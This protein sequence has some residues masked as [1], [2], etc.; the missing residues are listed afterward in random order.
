MLTKLLPIAMARLH[1]TLK[2]RL[3]GS[4]VPKRKRTEPIDYTGFRSFPSHC[5]LIWQKIE[6]KMDVACSII[7]GQT[8]ETTEWHGPPNVSVDLFFITIFYMVYGLWDTRSA[9]AIGGGFTFVG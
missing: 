1:K 4:S 5:P 9:F 6:W 8:E 7:F 3:C 2:L